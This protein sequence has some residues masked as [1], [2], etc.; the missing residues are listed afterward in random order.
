[1]NGKYRISMILV[2]IVGWFYAVFLACLVPCS[3]HVFV[4][5]IG[6]IMWPMD[7]GCSGM[8]SGQKLACT[9]AAKEL[10]STLVHGSHVIAWLGDPRVG[11]C[12]GF[13]RNCIAPAQCQTPNFGR[14]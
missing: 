12:V 1:M 13:P 14:S 7:K 3:W 2:L 5:S 10:S 4:A 6:R 11:Y 9:R 8:V